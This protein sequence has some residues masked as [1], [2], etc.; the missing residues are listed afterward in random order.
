[1]AEFRFCYFFL[2]ENGKNMH[3]LYFMVGPHREQT[4]SNLC[5]FKV[6]SSN[7]AKTWSYKLLSSD[8]WKRII[9]KQPWR[10]QDCFSAWQKKGKKHGISNKSLWFTT[11][12]E[13]TFLKAC[14]WLLQQSHDKWGN[15]ERNPGDI[16]WL[17]AFSLPTQGSNFTL[18]RGSC[19]HFS[20]WGRKQQRLKGSIW[21]PMCVSDDMLK[22]WEFTWT[23]ELQ[24]FLEPWKQLHKMSKKE[25]KRKADRDCI[26]SADLGR[27]SLF[28]SF[29]ALLDCT[30]SLLCRGFGRK[31]ENDK[32]IHSGSLRQWGW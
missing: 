2:K 29:C 12:N 15:T 22:F 9:E 28:S 26:C 16:L 24:S 1:M 13:M 17:T 3:T 30:L 20:N 4:P 7:W 18:L 23:V 5:Y 27:K 6:N 25:T 21:F 31:V 32:G 8:H 10:V 19:A 14:A 11:K